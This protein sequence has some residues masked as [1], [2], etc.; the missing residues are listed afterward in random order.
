[1]VT[2][3]ARLE[4]P[5]DPDFPLYA[6]GSGRNYLQNGNLEQGGA[7]ADDFRALPG[8]VY[9]LTEA[10]ALF[11]A[12][13]ARFSGNP[14]HPTARA[15]IDQQR[16][17]GRP[18][19]TPVTAALWLKLPAP[20][21]GELSL[22]VNVYYADG[23]RSDPIARVPVDTARTGVWQRVTATVQPAAGQQVTFAGVY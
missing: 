20:V 19:G 13:S 17:L 8:T 4:N 15:A 18:G 7:H 22:W 3:S 1:G 6:V 10:G 14:S 11:G 2:L 9:S 12:R 16:S 21:E 5:A 23:S